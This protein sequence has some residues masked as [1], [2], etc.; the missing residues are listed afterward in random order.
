MSD[1]DRYRVKDTTIVAGG[2]GVAFIPSASS[3]HLSIEVICGHE[4]RGMITRQLF[5]Y[6]QHDDHIWRWLNHHLRLWGEAHPLKVALAVE[7]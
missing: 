1:L 4:R 5:G 3:L 7:R 6:D 2:G